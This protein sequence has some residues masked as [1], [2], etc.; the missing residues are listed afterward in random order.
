[1]AN[2]SLQ[3]YTGNEGLM[4][5]K[6]LRGTLD[7][8]LYRLQSSSPHSRS[9]PPSVFLGERTSLVGW[10]CQL[11]HP[12]EALIRHLASNFRLPISDS[13]FPKDL[14]SL[15]YF[16]G[17]EVTPTSDGIILSQG[18]YIRDLLRRTNMVDAKPI[19][20]PAE[21]GSRLILSGDHLTDAHLYRSVVGSL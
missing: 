12:N 16:L 21:P 11:A 8:D 2:L 19:S 3:T 5:R 7:S 17:V 6:L 4:G 13:Y 1:M 18:K 14:G 10:H 15:N 9:S 20:S